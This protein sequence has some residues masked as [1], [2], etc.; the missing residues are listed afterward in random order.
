MSDIEEFKRL[1][2]DWLDSYPSRKGCVVFFDG[3]TFEVQDFANLPGH[4]AAEFATKYRD[5]V[6]KNVGLSD[7]MYEELNNAE[8]S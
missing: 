2:N 7:F 4:H 6:L 8:E 1:V 3:N 5:S